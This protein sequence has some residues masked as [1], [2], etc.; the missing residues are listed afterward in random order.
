MT[1]DWPCTCGGSLARRCSPPAQ[2][3]ALARRVERGDMAAKDHMIEANLRLV[4]HIAKRYQREDSGLTLTDLIQE[5]T[6]G[7]VRAVEKFDYRRGHR[8]ST[9]ATLWIRQAVGRAVADKGRMVRLPITVADQVRQLEIAERTLTT[10]LGG[11]PRD[12]ELA[13]DLGWRSRTSSACAAPAAAPPR[14]T[15]RSPTTA[16]PSSATWSPPPPPRPRTRRWPA[17]SA[18]ASPPRSA[19]SARSSAACS[20]SATASAARRRTRR[21]R[22][23]GRSASSRTRCARSRTARCARSARCPT[24]ASSLTLRSPWRTSTA[25]GWGAWGAGDCVHFVD[26]T[27]LRRAKSTLCSYSV[28]FVDFTSADTVRS[29]KCTLP[30]SPQCRC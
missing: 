2:E 19:S 20:S 18:P 6:I 11:P 3:Q 8:F 22:P 27:A 4:V 15:R 12:A 24:L 17:P 14:S 25:A 5:G 21:P 30:C 7:L 9:Y 1:T 29:T 16:R 23:R 10:R 26:L 28:H 13:A